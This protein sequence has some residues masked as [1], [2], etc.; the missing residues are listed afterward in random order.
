MLGPLEGHL[1]PNLKAGAPGLRRRPSSTLVVLESRGAVPWPGHTDTR[2]GYSQ[3][4][5]ASQSGPG[6]HRERVI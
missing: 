5:L 4:P 6:Q 3:G 1:L 2:R